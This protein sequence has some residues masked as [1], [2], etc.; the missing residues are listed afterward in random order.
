MQRTVDVCPLPPP[1]HVVFQAVPRPHGPA[2]GA[3]PRSGQVLRP[4]PRT[5]PGR[6]P[7]VRGPLRALLVGERYG[8]VIGLVMYA[9]D[10]ARLGRVREH[11]CC[12]PS[13]SNCRRKKRPRGTTRTITMSPLRRCTVGRVWG[14][15]GEEGGGETGALSSS[16]STVSCCRR[17]T[18]T[19]P[20][21]GLLPFLFSFVPSGRVRR[22]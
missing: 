15:E 13:T 3:R 11:R 20:G 1:V 8:L 4:S 6:S 9:P 22:A 14:E 17:A 19:P 10:N 5:G 12:R 21:R 2:S 18:R 7:V 16:V